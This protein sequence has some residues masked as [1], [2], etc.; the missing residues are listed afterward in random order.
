[1]KKIPNLLILSIIILFPQYCFSW[2][3]TGHR[4]IGQIAEELLDTT[5]KSKINTILN[6]TGIAMVSNWGDFVKSDPKFNNYYSWHYTNLEANLSRKQFDSA[7][8]TIKNGE[9]VFQ[10]KYLI[11]YLKRNQNDADMLKMLIHIVGDMFMP[12]HLGHKEDK[13]GNT[14]KIKFFN[15][16]TNIHA[17][18]DDK[19]IEGEDLSYTE[20]SN[21]LMNTNKPKFKKYSKKDINDYAWKTY[22]ITEDLYKNY[23]LTENPYQYIYKYKSIWESQLVSGGILLAKILHYIYN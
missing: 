7:V 3:K 21:Y 11:E 13:G 17:L 14:I 6:D 1:M 9:C 8:M 22:Q 16:N 18:W 15:Q 2:G 23:R 5:T 4:V 19:L 10:I 20:Y 12:F